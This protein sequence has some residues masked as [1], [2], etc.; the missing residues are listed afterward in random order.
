MIKYLK[1]IGVLPEDTAEERMK[2]LTLLIITLSCC[3]A[4]P[5]WSYAYYLMGLT[6]SAV[7]PL[8]YMLVMVPAIILFAIT[9][10]VNILLNIQLVAIFLCPTIMQWL[11]GG[12]LKGGVIILWAF[13]SPINALIF[14][15][16]KKAKFWMGMVI[17]TVLLTGYFN[18][19][20]ED[21]GNYTDQSLRVLQLTM[22]IAGATVVIYLAMEYFVRMIN[23]NH[24]LLEEEKKRSD[25]LLLNI[26]PAQVA[27]ELKVSGKS[28]PTLYTDTTIIFSDFKDFTQFSELFTPEELVSELGQCF[29]AFD[30]IVDKHGLEKI[31]TMGDAYMC[32]AGIPVT[33]EDG[34]TNAVKALMAALEIA[35]YVKNARQL[36]FMQGKIYWGI[37]IGIHTGDVVAGIVGKNKF[38]FDIW[39]DAVNTA[40]R[41]ETCS[42][43]GKVNISGTTY[44]IVKDYFDC[45]YRGKIS[46]KNKGELD[47]Y[48]VDGLKQGVYPQLPAANIEL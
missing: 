22:N 36:K 5:V 6:T 24:K 20:F 4:A 1:Q 34:K 40:S 28:K 39:G 8:L 21:F 2:K 19:Y 30:E 32:V 14:Q 12:Y 33:R 18:D 7:I 46:V 42:E 41:V 48:F 43:E 15:E 45:T 31:K 11:A 9:R 26:L 44:E 37:R 3:V 16:I 10:K 23:R 47:M 35:A 38:V 25:S 29:S 27:E 17:L 13:L